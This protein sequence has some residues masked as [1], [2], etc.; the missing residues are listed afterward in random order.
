[1]IWFS[2]RW[3]PL[4]GKQGMCH[5][6]QAH[7]RYFNICARRWRA[8]LFL[9]LLG[10]PLFRFTCEGLAA[11]WASFSK[12]FLFL[13]PNG[14][15]R[16]TGF[17]SLSSSVGVSSGR[18][19]AFLSFLFGAFRRYICAWRISSGVRWYWDTPLPFGAFSRS[20]ISPAIV[21]KSSC[22]PCRLS[23]PLCPAISTR[24][25]RRPIFSLAF[26]QGMFYD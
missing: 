18:D 8:Y 26:L 7:V 10:R 6:R 17:N 22:L 19:S 1:M 25:S 20:L 12:V 5:L 9:L 16:R 2:P 23:Y 24:F 3:R 21:S 14:L 11:S 13:L 15:S 4:I